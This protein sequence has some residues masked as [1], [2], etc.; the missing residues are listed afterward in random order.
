MPAVLT[1]ATITRLEKVA[2]DNGFDLELAR[3]GDWLAFASTQA[4]LRIWLTS[5]GDEL[6]AAALSQHNVVRALGD[7]G[8]DLSS[9]LPKGA[10]GGRTVGDIPALHRL[11]RR[12]FRLSRTLPDEPLHLFE[13]K[14]A[15]LPRETEA[16]RLVVQRVGQDIF[17]NALLDYW[18]GRCAITDLAVTELLRVSHIKPWAKCEL[19]AER[20][21]VFN[22]LL[23]APQL[24]AAFDRGF[25][26]VADDGTVRVSSL[27]GEGDRLVLGLDRPLRVRALAEGHRFYLA[28][29]AEH[30]FRP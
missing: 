30:L 16:E 23:L 11:V 10:A 9:P 21:D 1:A 13:A 3:E 19:D 2:A 20:L 7:H 15:G 27:L 25:I 24:D 22:G 14:V 8:F 28:W 26:T 5:F 12:A 17:R 29:H 18:E 4:P 6:F